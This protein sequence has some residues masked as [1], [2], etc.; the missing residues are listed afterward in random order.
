M[1]KRNLI[2]FFFASSMDEDTTSHEDSGQTSISE[3]VALGS[4]HGERDP[5]ASYSLESCILCQEQQ[6]VSTKGRAVV[7]TAFVQRSTVLSKSR[8]KMFDDGENFDPLYPP[9]DVYWGLHTSSCGH[10]MHSDC[11]QGYFDSVVAKERRALRLRQFIRLDINT[12]EFLCPLCG[13]ICNTVLPII[14]P[15]ALGKH[16]RLV[17]L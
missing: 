6:E 10:I 14:P 7:M 4:H 13:C 1:N 2:C 12:R 8:G 11:W 17:H 15:L 5:K 9:A 3:P 16:Q